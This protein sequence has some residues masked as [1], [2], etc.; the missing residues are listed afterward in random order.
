MP[1]LEVTIKT[2]DGNC[3]ASVFT[4]ADKVGP[5]PAVIFF[6]DGLGIRPAMWE[7]GQRLAD[8]GYLVLLPDLYYRF[9]S[10]PP[11]NPSEVLAD[12]KLREEL[13]KLVSSLD[14]DRKVADAAAFIEFLSS[15]PEVQGDRF[16]AVGYCMGGNASLVAAGVP[17]SICGGRVVSRRKFGH[18]PTR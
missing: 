15:R 1:R 17:R 12:P 2:R 18:G 10:Y 16:G 9:G 14:R 8:G 7:M 6:M 11:K 13:M 5:W 3:P 4:P